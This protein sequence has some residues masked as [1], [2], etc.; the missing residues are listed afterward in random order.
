MRQVIGPVWKYVVFR[1]AGEGLRTPAGS[2]R[3]WCPC[4]SPGKSRGCR[5]AR[6]SCP[7]TAR[8]WRTRRRCCSRASLTFSRELV[9]Q[10][11]PVVVVVVGGVP[12]DEV[13]V[14]AVQH[15]VAVR[16]FESFRQRVEVRPLLTSKTGRPGLSPSTRGC[17]PTSVPL[18]FSTIAPAGAADQRRHE[19]RSGRW[20]RPMSS[21]V[22]LRAARGRR[23]AGRAKVFTNRSSAR[24]P[25]CL[26]PNRPGRPPSCSGYLR[27]ADTD[28][29]D[30]LEHSSTLPPG[31]RYWC[32]G[33]RFSPERA[34]SRARSSRDLSVHVADH[35]LTVPLPGLLGGSRRASGSGG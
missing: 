8:P 4:R 2:G 28:R 35:S 32:W 13:H 23:R 10:F 12:V 24:R 7:C 21:V 14:A 25:G 31:A 19:H 9:D 26:S 18:T 16:V 22:M 29:C 15:G 20:R 34:R 3:Q 17:R 30:A 11:F 6:W 33:H 5:P 1:S 27:P